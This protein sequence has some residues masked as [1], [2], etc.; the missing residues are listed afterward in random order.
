[1]GSVTFSIE[2]PWGLAQVASIEAQ[3]L[4]LTPLEF[5]ERI[6]TSKLAEYDE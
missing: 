3:K 6:V 4:K 2:I 5:I 1:M